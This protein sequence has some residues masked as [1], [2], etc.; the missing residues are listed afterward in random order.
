[1]GKRVLGL[2]VACVLGMAG[3]AQAPD[4]R[5]GGAEAGRE[6]ETI[7]DLFGGEGDQF[8]CD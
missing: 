2:L 4:A 8:L 7:F 5:K 1:M 3:A 6:A